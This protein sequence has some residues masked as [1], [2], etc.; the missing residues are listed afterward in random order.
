MTYLV[1]RQRLTARMAF[2]HVLAQVI[3]D[4]VRG[5]PDDLR[6]ADRTERRHATPITILGDL[7]LMLLKNHVGFVFVAHRI[8]RTFAFS[9]S[10]LGAISNLA[11]SGRARSVMPEITSSGISVRP[12]WTK[13]SSG[14]AAY[15]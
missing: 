2:V 10:I 12:E 9:T 5:I 7:Y 4:S 6:L 13:H 8:S 3:N 1:Y 15:S 11:R 14:S